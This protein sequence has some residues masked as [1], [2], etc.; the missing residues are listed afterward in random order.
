MTSSFEESFKPL[1]KLGEGDFGG[2]TF[3][4]ENRNDRTVCVVKQVQFQAGFKEQVLQEIRK[5]NQ[6]DSKYIVPYRQP[7]MAIDSKY[8]FIFDTRTIK[9]CIGQFSQNF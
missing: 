2:L 3:A 9:Y 1:N 5:Y 4:A 7:I 8:W 6:I